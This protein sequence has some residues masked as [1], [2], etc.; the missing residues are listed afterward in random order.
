MKGLVIL[1][2]T[3]INACH[4]P[5][6]IDTAVLP[7]KSVLDETIWVVEPGWGRRDREWASPSQRQQFHSCQFPLRIVQAASG[8]SERA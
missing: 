7:Q 1:S 2:L 6:V 8:S 4:R 5:Q 3:V